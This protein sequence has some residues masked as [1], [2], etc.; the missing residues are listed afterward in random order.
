MATPFEAHRGTFQQRIATAH[1]VAGAYGYELGHAR[2]FDAR[3]IAG[4]QH[5]IAQ[6]FVVSA[7]ARF[8]RLRVRIAAPNVLPPGL[9][10]K[11]EALCDGVVQYSRDL[12]PRARVVEL[13][14]I[15]LRPPAASSSTTITIRLRLA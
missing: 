13:T 14:D 1:A 11:F 7:E 2:R 9:T 12:Q 15:A 5:E 6:T 3:M 10:W 4:D 8:V